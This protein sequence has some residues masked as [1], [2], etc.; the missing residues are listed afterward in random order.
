MHCNSENACVIS[1]N[2]KAFISVRQEGPEVPC[3]VSEDVSS[4]NFCKRISQN[5]ADMGRRFRR[6]CRR[7][8][9]AVVEKKKFKDWT[10]I[11]LRSVVL[12]RCLAT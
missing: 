3:D 4:D 5:S 6:A 11:I 8:S 2:K 7:D 1:R 10:T 9:E 12:Y